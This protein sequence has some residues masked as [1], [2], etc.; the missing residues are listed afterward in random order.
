M[1]NYKNLGLVAAGAAIAAGTLYATLGN[2]LETDTNH[3]PTHIQYMDVDGKGDNDDFA[4]GYDGS[5]KVELYVNDGKGNFQRVAGVKASALE[6]AAETRTSELETAT[7]N[8]ATR[9][10]TIRTSNA[11]IRGRLREAQAPKSE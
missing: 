1:V 7:K 4:V 6:S 8:H 3:T 10:E 11:E 2:P 9:L 5:K